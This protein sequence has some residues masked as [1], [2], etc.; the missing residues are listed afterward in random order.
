MYSLL[1]INFNT[2]WCCLTYFYFVNFILY[3]I[4]Q[5][6]HSY[7]GN[8]TAMNF[9]C[10]W[11]YKK[12]ELSFGLFCGFALCVCGFIFFF[13]F[14]KTQLV[15]PSKYDTAL[16]STDRV[17]VFKADSPI[18]RASTIPSSSVDLQVDVRLLQMEMFVWWCL[19]PLSTIFQLYRVCQFYWWRKPECPEK[20]TRKSLTNF[21]TYW[22]NMISTTSMTCITGN[23]G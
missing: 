21:S 20:T 5:I 4:D 10:N 16:W 12:K 1:L 23:S 7:I 11:N 19:T 22:M 15:A 17:L 14:S 9:D 18:E 2:L 3:E 13:F 8:V 6:T